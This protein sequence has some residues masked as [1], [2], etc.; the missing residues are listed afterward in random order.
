MFRHTSTSKQLHYNQTSKIPTAIQSNINSAI[1]LSDQQLCHLSITLLSCTQV[2]VTLIWEEKSRSWTDSG[3]MC[4]CTSRKFK[5]FE[6]AA[7]GTICKIAFQSW[8]WRPYFDWRF[9]WIRFYS[10]DSINP[11]GVFCFCHPRQNLLKSSSDGNNLI[12]SRKFVLFVALPKIPTFRTQT[13]ELHR[14]Q[15]PPSE[16]C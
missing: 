6:A 8:C 9:K 4:N 2:F 14:R 3:S 5:S 7:G 10:K 16:I 15:K 11:S 12:S 1:K 13:T